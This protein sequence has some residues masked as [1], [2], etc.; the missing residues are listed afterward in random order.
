MGSISAWGTTEQ[1]AVEIGAVRQGDS[2]ALRVAGQFASVPSFGQSYQATQDGNGYST[3]DIL[4]YSNVGGV[5]TWTNETTATSISPPPSNDIGPIGG[6]SLVQIG[7]GTST[8]GIVSTSGED[9]LAVAIIDSDG[10]QIDTFGP[11][12]YTAGDV[13]STPSGQV[14]LWQ[15]ASNALTPATVAKPLP[16]SSAQVVASYVADLPGTGYIAG[17][18]LWQVKGIDGSLSWVNATAQTAITEPA[19]SNISAIAESDP[20]QVIA[21]WKAIANDGQNAFLIGDIVVAIRDGNDLVYRNLT[22]STVITT[23]FSETDLIP[24]GTNTYQYQ[25]G[26]NTSNLF[27]NLIGWDEAGSVALVSETSPLPVQENSILQFATANSN[28]TGYSSGDNLAQIFVW[29]TGYQWI[30]LTTEQTITEPVNS[31]LS[32][33]ALNLEEAFGNIG[34]TAATNNTGTWSFLSLF[35]RIVV[36]LLAEKLVIS[37]SIS[38]SGDTEIIAAPGVGQELVIVR[39]R[40]QME[41][42]T[43]TTLVLSN[44]VDNLQRFRGASES[45]GFDINYPFGSELRIGNNNAYTANLSAGTSFGYSIMYYIA[46]SSTQLPV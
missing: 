39:E 37:G 46:N 11:H 12:S 16:V 35:K 30:N 15:E 10:N 2:Y 8:V 5:V 34:D 6:G 41:A 38:S 24:F 33:A 25:A 7:N 18:I 3:G 44:G 31:H 26:T 29:P 4:T 45:D 20:V 22:Q 17:D 1:K 13:V 21:E 43:P 40:W 27:S 32:N 42:S 14:V 19:F 36:R 23:P 28:G 9:G